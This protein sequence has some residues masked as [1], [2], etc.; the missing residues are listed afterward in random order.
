MYSSQL[1]II[2]FFPQGPNDWMVSDTPEV[3]QNGFSYAL[4][5]CLFYLKLL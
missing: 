2:V 5:T 4:E 3:S 1:N